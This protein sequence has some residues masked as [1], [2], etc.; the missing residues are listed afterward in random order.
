[1]PVIPLLEVVGKPG[2]LPPA[3]IVSELPKLN[4]GAMFGLIVTVRVVDVV[5]CPAE[6]V[7]I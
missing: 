4:V 2:T 3:H 1:M 6:G 5:H 7:N